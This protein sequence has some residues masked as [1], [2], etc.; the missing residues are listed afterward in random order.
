MNLLFSMPNS[1]FQPCDQIGLRLAKELGHT[2]IYAV[3]A[4]GDFPLPRVVNYAKAT[5][6]SAR[7]DAVMEEFGEM[8][9]A[10]GEYLKTHSMLEMLLYMNSDARVAKEVGL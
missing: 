10:E 4:D 7:L 8:V 3:D 1:G 9:K 2:A 6:Q 5:G